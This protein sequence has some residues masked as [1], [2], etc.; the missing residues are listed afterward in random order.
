[1]TVPAYIVKRLGWAVVLAFSISL[2][3]FTIFYVIPQNAVHTRQS[4]TTDLGKWTGL[5]GSMATQYAQWLSHIA[6]GSLGRSFY[7]HQT[8]LEMIGNALP[9]TLSLVL[10]GAVLWL[11]IAVPVAILSALRPRSLVDRSAT[12]LVLV[13]L[14]VHPLWLG[15]ML[16]YLFGFRLGWLPTNG[17]CDLIHP[18]TIC[19]GPAQ[20]ASHLVLPWV[21][22]GLVFA[23]LYMRMIRASVAEAL[24]EDFVRQARAKGLSEWRAVTS[25]VLPNALV[26]VVAMLA[27]D[28]GRLALP[29]ALFVETAF[30]LPGLGRLFYQSVL[31]ND[32]P[33]MV[34]V[35]VVSALAVVVCNLVADLLFP[36]L[37]PRIRLDPSPA[38][39]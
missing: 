18:D 35:I 37:D 25:H 10:G 32:L 2:V 17:Y 15:L 8:V 27:M 11:L 34:G 16:S 20:W 13:G 31:R 21:T 39:A 1:M 30:G 5:H 29:T 24:N 3:T 14:S 19:G 36:V 23:A 12:V 6:H 38:P 33:V 7:V 26:P 9:V 4:G 22:F 28:I